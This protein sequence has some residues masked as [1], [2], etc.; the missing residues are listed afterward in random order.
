V[1]AFES[2][3]DYSSPSATGS[4]QRL[5]ELL[6][7]N[8]LAPIFADLT[9]ADLAFPVVRALVPGLT[10]MADFDRFSRLTPRQASALRRLAEPRAPSKFCDDPLEG[11]FRFR[12][13]SR[14][15]SQLQI[16]R[17]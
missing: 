7:A 1:R 4:L 5:Q 2:L 12:P 17:R 15:C 14:L 13:S 8:G 16:P 10:I 9:R 3:P 6:L 11:F